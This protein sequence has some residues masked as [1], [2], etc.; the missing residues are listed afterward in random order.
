MGLNG[1][2]FGLYWDSLYLYSLKSKHSVKNHSQ[3]LVQYFEKKNKTTIWQ[4]KKNL[5]KN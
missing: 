4:K 2:I 5:K 3:F 1:I